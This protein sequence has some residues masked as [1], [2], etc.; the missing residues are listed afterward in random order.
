MEITDDT[1]SATDTLLEPVA[2]E[3]SEQDFQ[4]VQTVI[5]NIRRDKEFHKKA[6]DRMRRDMHVATWGAEKDWGEDRYRAN[7]AGRHVKQR[8]AA[9]YAKNPKA[10][11]RRR[12]QMDF[13]SW[14]ENPQSLML[15]MQ[16][17]QM[18]EQTAQ[19]DVQ[20]DP[21]TG[22]SVPPEMP[23]G[24]EEAQALVADFQQGTQRRQI[25]DRIGK[26]LELLFAYAME[27]QQPLTFKQG[28]KSVVRRA[29]TTGVGYVELGF[30]RE[31]GPSPINES[32]L[33]DATVRLSHLERI[34]R[35]MQEGDLDEDA[36]E[37]AELEH[38]ISA[39]Q[40]E[41]NIILNEGLA[42]DYPVSTRVI[43]DSLCTSLT[44]FV[45]ARH[46]TLEY[47]YT[48]D[49]I[50]EVFGVDIGKNFTAYD[51]NGIMGGDTSANIVPDDEESVSETPKKAEGLVC[52]W[53]YFDKTTGLVYFVADGYKEFL[54]A[55]A[56][57][58]VFV[59]TFWPVFALT[60]NE[61]ENETELFP[62]SDV[63]LLLDMQKEHNRSRDGMR[64]HRRAARPKWVSATGAFSDEDAAT[65]IANMQ[66]FE[67]LQLNMDPSSKIGDILQVVP[68]PG[69]DP[70]LY[71]TGQIFSDVQLV[72]GT[73]QSSF[74]GV[75]KATATESAIAA[76]S[77][78][79]SDGA[80]IDDLDAF[81]TTIARSAGQILQTEMSEEIVQQ[82]VGPGAMW[83]ELTLA[84]I[85][86]EIF[87][88]V[89]AGSTG[90]PNQ[91]VEIAN[92]ERLL[93]M[94]LQMPSINQEE[95][96]REVLRRMDDKLDLTKL[97]MAGMPSIVAQNQNAQPSPADPAANPN[98]QGPQGAANGPA[99]PGG[100]G[101]SMAAFGSNQV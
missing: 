13:A 63:T 99:A 75:S 4:L 57:P 33:N 11:A 9:L 23:P 43:P 10:T 17:I 79:S 65:K 100:A 3:T 80:S 83:P 96:A 55:P 48:S 51:A 68:V 71:E 81:L 94:L 26:T 72:V 12:E 36:P 89:A 98:M 69:V 53:K 93:P 74:G 77:S 46:I 25:Y 42:V 7:I 39:L 29:L 50:M 52:V 85:A 14:D 18:A 31:V 5:G 84:E 88:E 90:K 49:E 59:E 56:P 16:T 73:Q 76:N 40:G 44:G 37:R 91:A 66:P 19:M 54:R 87:L 8:T 24:F 60:F 38:S 97:I 20:V 86:G 70:N 41:E 58:D 27:Q 82:I 34:A 61:V 1:T 62:P 15:A 78:T 47:T 95:L 64:E 6:F 22:M 28:M 32:R 101:G 21:M 35:E 67:M 2:A 45:G 92:M 30:Q